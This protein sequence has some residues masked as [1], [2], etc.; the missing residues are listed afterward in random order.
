MNKSENRII[1]K[2]YRSKD[3]EQIEEK[4][5]MLGNTKL[6][7]ITF[8]N[9]RI[10]S[11]LI[12]F[13]VT[14]YVTNLGYIY[15]P[16]IT[17][18]YFYLYYYLLIQS[19]LKQ[20][21]KRLDREALHFFEILT[22]TLES[23]RN[24]ENSLEVTVANV[25]SE[26][27]NEFRR[28][29]FEVKFGKSLLEALEDMKKRMPSETINNILLNITQTDV[30]GNS[31]LETMYNQIDFLRD[32]QILEIKGEINKIPNKVSIISVLFVVPL[33]LML[34]LGPFIIN[35]LG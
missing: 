26:L 25:N 20:R 23:G 13:L 21:I 33:I 16:F 27:S 18:A 24:L 4:I 10:I 15:A 29:L 31:I 11:S 1:R 6:D 12:V 7:A 17:L 22:L 14:I 3:I 9:F 35:F 30:F 34:I 28:V 2:I 32:K 8:M 19:P 5:A